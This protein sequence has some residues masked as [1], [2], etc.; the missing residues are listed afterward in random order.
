MPDNIPLLSNRV[1]FRRDKDKWTI[2]TPGGKLLSINDTA[3]LILHYCDG[4]HSIDEIEGELRRVLQVENGADLEG[5]I[6]QFLAK[7]EKTGC[8][9]LYST[10]YQEPFVEVVTPGDTKGIDEVDQNYFLSYADD[11]PPY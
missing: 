9:H 7:M 3:K 1:K 6:D 11:E 4:N 10:V 2:M 5:Q 8:V